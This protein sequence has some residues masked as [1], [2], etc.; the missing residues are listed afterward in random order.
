[1]KRAQRIK[2]YWLVTSAVIIVMVFF[3]L[4]TVSPESTEVPSADALYKQSTV[5]IDVRVQD[6]LARMTLQE[7][8]GQMALVERQS[9]KA[10]EDITQFGLGALLSGSGSKPD[11]TSAV[12]WSRMV[13]GYQSAATASRL[14]IP[15][16]YGSDAIHGH[17]HVPGATVFPHAIG[18]GASKDEEL[19]AAVAAATAAETAATGVNWI[20]APNLDQP[21]DIRWGRVYEAFSD[22]PDVVARLGAAYVRG[23]HTV[24]APIVLS[25]KHF[26]GLGDMAWQTSTN[27]NFKIDQGATVADEK[28]LQETLLPP[29]AAA[30]TTGAE[31]VMVGLNSWGGTKLAANRYLMTD[32]L[33]R[34]LNFQGFIVSDWYGVYEIPGGDF[35]AAVRAINAGVDM[36][37]LPFDYQSFVRNV[38]WAVRLHLIPQARIDDAVARILR[39]K[40]AIGL[41]DADVSN[42]TLSATTIGSVEHRK[43][44][45]KAVAASQ[46]LLKNDNAT[47]PI[48]PA[49]RSIRVAGSAADNVGMQSGAWTIEWQGIDGTWLPESTSIL[50]GIRSRAGEGVVVSYDQHGMFSPK[51]EKADLGIAVVG[52]KPY[53]EGWGDRDYPILSNDDLAA[54]Q[55]VQATSKRVVVVIVSGRPLFVSNEIATWDAVVAAWLPGSEGAGV[56]DVLFG[57]TPFTASLPLPWPHHAEQLPVAVDETTADDTPL[58]FPRGFGLRTHNKTN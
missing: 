56:T 4:K 9:L 19:V 58:L 5:P 27:K 30:I 22:D 1:M 48:T 36:V 38:S 15:L 54:I 41:F 57:D 17:A 11:D 50:A 46:V 7:K 45:R 12:G 6:L 39:V 20:Y 34:Q 10:S 3:F 47:L 2:T 33:K 40:F 42:R 51:T 29:F 55:N 49:V 25:L 16:L 43:L 53:A 35:I 14:G 32:V 26:I 37:M 44:A 21:R 28:A 52:E 23:A 8:I 31:S 24:Q 13:A 18:L